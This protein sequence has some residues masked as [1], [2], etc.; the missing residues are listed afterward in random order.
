MTEARTTQAGDGGVAQAA[1]TLSV[2]DNRTGKT[3]EIEITD[4]T[5]RAMDFRQIKVD[6]EDF[7][8]MSYDPAF[9]NTAST[10]SS[11]TYIDGDKGILEYRGY[12]I[13]QLAERSTYIEV[14]YLL[15]HGE[16]P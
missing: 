16:L 11:I 10:R 14:A 13:E 7:G 9:T 4:G 2:T 6:D 15:V 8:L 12:P 1:E 3:Y 5:V